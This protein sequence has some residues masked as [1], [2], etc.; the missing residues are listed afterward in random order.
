[1]ASFKSYATGIIGSNPHKTP[2]DSKPD[3]TGNVTIEDVKWNIAVWKK[4]N[5]AKQDFDFSFSIS[6][7]NEEAKPQAVQ[8]NTL[9]DDEP[10]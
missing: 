9:F 3:F 6:R 7:P 10:F 8:P 1:M 4:F 2:A 5:E